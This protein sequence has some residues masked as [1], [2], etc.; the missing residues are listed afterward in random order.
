MTQI[1]DVEGEAAPPAPQEDSYQ[2]RDHGAGV[3]SQVLDD[4]GAPVG[5]DAQGAAVN[6]LGQH[7]EDFQQEGQRRDIGAVP[8]RKKRCEG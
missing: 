4:F 2:Q 1:G 3:V 7:R 6:L 5:P 8:G